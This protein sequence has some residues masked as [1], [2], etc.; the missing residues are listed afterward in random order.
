M[1]VENLQILLSI[2]EEED[3]HQ[4]L[5]FQVWMNIQF[6]TLPLLGIEFACKALF[7]YYLKLHF[8]S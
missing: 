7:W 4:G 5:L 1:F 6:P 2:V 8:F 3:V